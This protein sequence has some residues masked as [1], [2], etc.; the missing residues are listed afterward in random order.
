MIMTLI[1]AELRFTAVTTP[2]LPSQHRQKL[3]MRPNKRGRSP[4]DEHQRKK[5]ITKRM[6]GMR[7][8]VTRCEVLSLPQE[9][10]SNLFPCF[11]FFE[12]QC[13]N[14]NCK[15]SHK[16]CDYTSFCV[17]GR[18]RPDEDFI[19]FLE[20]AADI[21]G[22][23]FTTT[24]VASYQQRRCRVSVARE[25]V[26]ATR[27]RRREHVHSV[28]NALPAVEGVTDAK[29]G[30]SSRKTSVRCVRW[31]VNTT[32]PITWSCPSRPGTHST[33]RI[34]VAEGRARS[35]A[36]RQLRVR[37]TQPPCVAQ[38]LSTETR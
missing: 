7:T 28:L 27:Q 1:T 12:D 9:K 35:K 32:R 10:R 13:N 5:P 2:A 33:R 24:E 37:P 14:S 25:K 31:G 19:T 29:Q 38:L 8:P 15:H 21:V 22:P 23:S 6:R 36:R 34:S 11:A 20:Y 4:V 18:P 30:E 3:K 26:K 17:S 16:A